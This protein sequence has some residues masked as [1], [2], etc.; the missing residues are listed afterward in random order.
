MS[1]L[2]T[3][4][5]QRCSYT[6]HQ[7]RFAVQPGSPQR[8]GHSKSGVNQQ[9]IREI[10][11]QLLMGENIFR[12]RLANRIEPV[13]RVRHKSAALTVTV[14]KSDRQIPKHLDK[15]ILLMRQQHQA[16]IRFSRK[17]RL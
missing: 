12:L 14:N 4:F 3:H 16:V 13:C 17:Q 11:Q 10:A 2:I 8:S 5:S 6:S 7:I 1:H 9:V 15:N